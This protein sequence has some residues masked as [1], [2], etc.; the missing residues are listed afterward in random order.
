MIK[1]RDCKHHDE[2]YITSLQGQGVFR[3]SYCA[4]LPHD[5]KIVEADVDRMCK[6]FRWKQDDLEVECPVCN[7]KIPI[8]EVKNDN[9]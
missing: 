2:N 7:K 9:S 3:F 4:R 1:C 8:G 6:E 5:M